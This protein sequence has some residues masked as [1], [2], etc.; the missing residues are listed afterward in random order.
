MRC[1]VLVATRA[2]GM[3]LAALLLLQPTPSPAAAAKEPAARVRDFDVAGSVYS[4][5]FSPDGTRLAAQVGTEIY[6]WDTKTGK[7]LRRIAEEPSAGVWSVAFAPDGK[8]VYAPLV[9]NSVA[10]WDVATG[11]LARLFQGHTSI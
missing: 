10:A 1:T 6:L 2:A 11:K 5:A 8:T 7:L 9:D 4:L 3:A